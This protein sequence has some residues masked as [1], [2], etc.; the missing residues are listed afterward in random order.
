MDEVADLLAGY[1]FDVLLGSV[2]WLGAWRFDVLD[3]PAGAGRVGRPRTSTQVWDEYTRAMEELGG[4]RGLRRLRPSRPGQDRR[5]GAGGARRV[6]RPD[7]RGG[8]A[9]GHGRRALVGRLAEAGAARSTRP[10][11]CSSGSST[12]GVPLTTASDAHTL[13]DVADRADDLRSLLAAGRG[14][15]AAGVPGAPALRRPVPGGPVRGADGGLTGGHAGRA[16]LRAHQPGRRP[17]RPSPAAAR[18]LG[19]PGRPVL[20]RPGPAGPD[21]AAEAREPRR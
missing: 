14:H 20:L 1:P 2:H 9:L 7:R 19:D 5:P 21:G 13:P 15:R 6:L 8:G 10:H 4:L 16:G 3:D 11:R 12:A 18:H 17:A